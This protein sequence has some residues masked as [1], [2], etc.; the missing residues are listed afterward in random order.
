M[1]LTS[2]RADRAVMLRAHAGGSVVDAIAMQV[3]EELAET[4]SRVSVYTADLTDLPRPAAASSHPA[5][6]AVRQV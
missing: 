6:I 5:D 4:G 2:R 3:A 1:E